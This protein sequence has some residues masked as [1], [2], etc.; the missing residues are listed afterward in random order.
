MHPREPVT[1]DD[2]AESREFRDFFEIARELTG[3]LVTLV[4]PTGARTKR[5][6]PLEVENPLC[7]LIKAQPAGLE[8]CLQVD[9]CHYEEAVKN[10]RGIRYACHAGLMDLAVPVYV[11]GRHV[12]TINCGQVLTAPPSEAG[13]RAVQRRLRVLRLDPH[14]A[15]RAY[16][17]SPW[18]PPEK[19]E[20]AL[21]LFAFFAEH[22]GE[23]GRRLKE[24]ERTSSLYVDA[25][26]RY[27]RERF[28]EPLALADVARHIGLSPAYFS[29][30]FRR[31]VGVNWCLYL[32]Q[33]RIEAARRLLE[34][35]S[36]RVT[37]IAFET[38]FNNLTHFNRVFRKLE[39]CA[40]GRWRA[41]QRARA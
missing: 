24:A 4:D 9:R 25:A 16:F 31:V 14:R 39:G 37:D 32:Q 21:K 30:L 12:A 17:R 34:K 7:R 2:L 41:R 3:I 11:E 20:S 18:L 28:R 10:R 40:P 35:S 23:V 15:R 1:F 27:A 8:A 26:K 36:H 33:T 13:W 38:G 22:F 6:F 29:T 5:L 19:L